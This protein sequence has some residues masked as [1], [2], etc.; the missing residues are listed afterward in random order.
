MQTKYDEHA[1]RPKHFADGHEA[2]W[3][4]ALEKAAGTI[5]S[6]NPKD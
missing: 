4:S 5:L 6:L 2:G 1:S 3:C